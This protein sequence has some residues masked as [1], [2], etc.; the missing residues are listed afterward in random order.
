MQGQ[1]IGYVRVSSY[2]QNPE[3]QLEQTQVGKLFTDKASGKDTQRPQL[4]AM[5][6]AA[7]RKLT[8]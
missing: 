1:R 7:D 2:D 8:Q 4:E 6:V 3:R 5:L